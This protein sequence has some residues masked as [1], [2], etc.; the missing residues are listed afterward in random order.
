MSYKPNRIDSENVIGALAKT[1]PKTFFEDA[2]L[3]L[4]LKKN[5]LADLEADGFPV[6]HVMLAPAV[7]WYMSHVLYQYK[8][9][10]GAKRVDLTGKE[11]GTVTEQEEVEARKTIAENNAQR[12]A[13]EQR[14]PVRTLQGL[15]A[16][17]RI[18]DDQVKKLDAPP[19]TKSRTTIAPELMRLHEALVAANATLT[20]TSDRALCSAMAA[21]ALGIVI[22][23]A[24]RV[25]KELQ[26]E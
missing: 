13:R 11:V 24:Q 12:K 20:N 9:I 5:I 2:K 19:M 6:N 26:E 3:R 22:K 21:A 18:P 1:Y 8:L 10:Q 23:E 17:G 15:H 4:P 7:D 14:D 25:I 16:A